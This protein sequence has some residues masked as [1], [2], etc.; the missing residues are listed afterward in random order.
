MKLRNKI[1]AI[2]A[3]AMLAFTGVG[4]AAWVF[5]NTVETKEDASLTNSLHCAVELN[6]DLHLKLN[7][8]NISDIYLI[9]DAPQ[10][11]GTNLVDGGKGVFWAADAQGENPI[12]DGVL[13]LT[14]SLNYVEND[15]ED[16]A[17]VTVTFKD[18]NSSFVGNNYVEFGDV[19]IPDAVVVTIAKGTDYESADFDLPTVAYTAEIDE[20]SSV[21]EL[22]HIADDIE[23][24]LGYSA[25]ITARTLNAQE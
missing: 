24:S 8:E 25:K 15:I 18:N 23:I 12:E 2:T 10:T 6:D 11:G 5:N 22:S 9:F 19:D 4:F 20:I 13:K 1:A 3:A 16:L 7:G 17:T 14:G 21:E